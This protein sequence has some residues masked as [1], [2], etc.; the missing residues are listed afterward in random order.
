MRIKVSEIPDWAVRTVP[1][2]V[3]SGDLWYNVGAF[4]RAYWYEGPTYRVEFGRWVWNI[5]QNNDVWKT[6]FMLGVYDPRADIW[7]TTDMPENRLTS[8]RAHNHRKVLLDGLRA[9]GIVVQ[10]VSHKR[11][12]KIRR[13]G[14]EKVVRRRFG[15]VK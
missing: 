9:K 4:T 6:K 7:Y 14:M 8:K 13:S 10:E 12:M 1:F 3:N 15:L 11:L 2:S 5:L